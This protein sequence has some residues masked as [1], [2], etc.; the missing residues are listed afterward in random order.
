MSVAVELEEILSALYFHRRVGEVAETVFAAGALD[1]RRRVLGARIYFDFHY[2]FVLRLTAV[3]TLVFA[4][5]FEPFITSD[6]DL[7]AVVPK[8]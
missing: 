6:T 8:L 2:G 1:G 4:S 5:F 3:A 7:L